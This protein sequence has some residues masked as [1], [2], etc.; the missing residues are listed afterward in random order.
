[1]EKDVVCGVQV[2]ENTTANKFT[3]KGRTF[4]FCSPACVAEFGLRP[5]AY[6]NKEAHIHQHPTAVFRLPI[7]K[8]KP[9]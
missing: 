8:T 2:D 4:F 6:A 1:M 3:Y 9:R 5:E 7:P